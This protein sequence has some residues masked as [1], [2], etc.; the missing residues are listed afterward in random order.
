[1]RFAV[2]KLSRSDLTFF[3]PQ[4]RIQNAGNQKSINLNRDVFVDQLFPAFPEVLTQAGGQ[5]PVRLLIDG[6]GLGHDRIDVR[7]KLAKG[8]SY[9]N[10][11][12]NGEFVRNPEEEGSRFNA[13]AE[14]DLAVLAFDGAGAPDLIRLFV[15]SASEAGAE[16]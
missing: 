11:R 7:R 15:L 14:G 3:E 6:P 16:G 12:L 1:M 13:L 5:L 10:Y 2:K 8:T 9:K 4:F